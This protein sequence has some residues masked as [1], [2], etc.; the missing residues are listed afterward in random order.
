MVGDGPAN[1]TLRLSW[2]HEL[3][4]DA[5]DLSTK[6]LSIEDLSKDLSIKASARDS[7]A[8]YLMLTNMPQAAASAAAVKTIAGLSQNV[9]P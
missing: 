6:D 8:F 1:G 2:R 7:A 5:K 9:P 3:P 4:H